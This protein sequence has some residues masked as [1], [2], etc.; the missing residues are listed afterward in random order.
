MI[1]EALRA[2]RRVFV[3][4]RVGDTIVRVVEVSEEPYLPPEREEFTGSVEARL[5]TTQ[6]STLDW[7]SARSGRWGTEYDTEIPKSPRR[8]RLHTATVDD[9][10]WIGRTLEGAGIRV[11][12]PGLFTTAHPL[13]TR[14]EP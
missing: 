8:V 7:P 11:Q 4:G 10:E 1:R 13:P 2:G 12:N 9:R 5:A 3:L 14:L 6:S